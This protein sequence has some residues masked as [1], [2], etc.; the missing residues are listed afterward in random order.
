V[1]D[2]LALAVEAQA[3]CT[4]QGVTDEMALAVE[5]QAECTGAWAVA[6]EVTLAE[7]ALAECTGTVAVADEDA[8]PLPGKTG[9]KWSMMTVEATASLA[10]SSEVARDSA[11]PI[12][13]VL[14]MMRASCTCGVDDLVGERR[15][16]RKTVVEEDGVDVGSG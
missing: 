6:N 7:A 13:S 16:S 10:R 12:G 9:S 3:E 1:T 14:R 5:A 11:A 2:E 8:P 15:L 4:A